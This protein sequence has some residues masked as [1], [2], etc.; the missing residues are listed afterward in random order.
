MTKKQKLEVG[1]IFSINI[2]RGKFVFGRCLIKVSI[3]HLIEVFDYISK[4]E[5]FDVSITEERLF[6]PVII[7]SYSLFEAKRKEGN[8]NIITKTDNFTPTNIEHL[9]YTYGTGPNRFL[10]DVFGNE[11]II[12]LQES[13]NYPVYSPQGDYD[14]KQLIKSAKI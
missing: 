1:S 11:T 6:E 9:R 10:T 5:K 14:I 13:K 3:G 12:L 7:D 8:W 4:E 2:G